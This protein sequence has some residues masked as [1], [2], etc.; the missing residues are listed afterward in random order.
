MVLGETV[1]LT[2]NIFEGDSV[3]LG[4]SREHA[5]AR[6]IVDLKLVS[7]RLIVKLAGVNTMEDATELIDQAIYLTNDQ[8]GTIEDER[9]SIGD[10]EGCTVVSPDGATL[11]SISEVWLLPANDVWVLTREDGH[12]IPLPVIDSVI[13]NVDIPKKTITA[14]LLDGLDTVDRNTSEQSDA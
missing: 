9:Y 5:V 12:T 14:Q 11:G 3:G 8:A 7:G 4:F 1:G 13:L 10:I 6:S 2:P